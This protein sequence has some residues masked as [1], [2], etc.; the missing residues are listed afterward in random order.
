MAEAEQQPRSLP[1]AEVEVGGSTRLRGRG[2]LL[3]AWRVGG[4]GHIGF[5]M[6]RSLCLLRDSWP[7]PE[8]DDQGCNDSF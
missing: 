8:T 7:L 2:N 5:Q 1:W 6:E 4:G 3:W